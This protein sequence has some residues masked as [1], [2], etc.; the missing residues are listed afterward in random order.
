MGIIEKCIGCFFV[1]PFLGGFFIKSAIK[2]G[3]CDYVKNQIGTFQI[4]FLVGK[5]DISG[6]VS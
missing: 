6:L 2:M 5:K 1:Y 4:Y 3:I